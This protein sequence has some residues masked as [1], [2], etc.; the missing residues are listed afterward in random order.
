MENINE[1][2]EEELK[3]EPYYDSESKLWGYKD[4]NG[5]VHIVPQFQEA[6]TFGEDTLAIVEKGGISY[7]LGISGNLYQIE[8]FDQQYELEPYFDSESLL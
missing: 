5:D 6:S 1:T 2:T 8:W 7:K 4:Q 3:L